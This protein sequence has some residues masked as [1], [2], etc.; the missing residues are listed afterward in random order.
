MTQRHTRYSLSL[1]LAVFLTG[2]A[3]TAGAQDISDVEREKAVSSETEDEATSR[4][5][6]QSERL[7]KERKKKQKTQG[8]VSKESV[9]A[10]GMSP[11]EIRR[12]KRRLERKNRQMID[13]L[14]RLIENDPYN[15]QKPQWMFQKAEL[16]WELR[17]MEYM[18]K[19]A[20]YNQ[21]LQAARQGTTDE[22]T[23]QEPAPD[24]EA[25]Q[26]IYKKIL[27][28][29]PD[30]QRLDEVIYRLG[31]GLL[32]ADKGTQ[33]ISY[34]QRLV[35]NYP[36]SKYIPDANLALAEY[37]FKQELL[38]AARDKYKAVLK[39]P[40]DPNY[41]YALY[42]LAWVFYNQNQYRQSIKTFK[43]VVER[44]NKKLGFQNQAINDMVLAYSEIQDGWEELRGYLIDQ[45]DK[46]LAYEKLGQLA[47]LYESQ[48][49]DREAIEVYN[50]FI[51]DRS[52]HSKVP[53]WMENIVAAKKRINVDLPK[54]ESTINEFVAYLSP[55]G[56]WWES[57][58][59]NPRNNAVLFTKASLAYLAN[60]YH[61]R[62]QKQDQKTFYASATKYYRKYIDRFPKD[63]ASF[64]MNYFLADILLTQLE[65]YQDAAERY[66]RVVEMYKKEEYPKA[67]EEKK[68]ELNSI[69]QD[70]AYGRVKAYDELVKKNHE[71]S[72][73]VK[74]ARFQEK[75][76]GKTYQA[77]NQEKGPPS[78]KEP[79]E[80]EP[81]LEYEKG[82]VKASDQYSE[83]F[84]KTDITPT[85]D[86]V[87]AEVYKARG[88]YKECID[89]YESIIENAPEH[90]YA[91][92][93]GNSLLEANYVLENWDEVERW[94]RHLLDNKIFD[95]TPKPK[96][97]SA[98]AFAINERAKDLKENDETR[99]AASELLRLA[100][101]FPDSKLTPG[102]IFNAAAIYES[103]D[104]IKKAV[105]QY[106]RVVAK[107]PKDEKAPEALFVLGLIAESR[108]NFAKAAGYFERL[109]NE[110]YK[111]SKKSAKA[112]YNAATLREAME[113]WTKAISTYEQY[114]ELFPDRDD[115]RK[116]KLKLAYLEKK[117]EN[118]EKSRERFGTFLER[119]DLKPPEE[120][121]VRTQI[122]LLLKKTQ[123]DEWKED[124]KEH[125][126]K[127]VKLWG[128]LPKKKKKKTREWAAHSRFLLAERQYATFEE[129]GLEFPLSQLKDSMKDKAE[130][131]SKAEKTYFKVI[132][133]KS[134]RWSSASAYR[135]GNMYSDYYQ[136]IRDLPLPEGLNQRQKFK[137]RQ[138]LDRRAAPLQ[139]KAVKAYETAL[140]VALR[141]QAYNEWSRKSAREISDLKKQSFPI[142][143]QKGVE[144]EHGQIKFYTPE[145]LVSFD[146]ALKRME[147]RDAR[148]PDEPESPEEGEEG[149]E[150]DDGGGEAEQKSAKAKSPGES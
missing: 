81:L 130:K 105:E 43:R 8:P 119:D 67:L 80:R 25:A 139:E 126:E 91:S 128:E 123:P 45:R 96:L 125:F 84:P 86:F 40:K 145:P 85:V 149:K 102:A 69:V 132:D 72:I 120:V 129:V 110:Q 74:M 5:Q 16:T 146:K 114:I 148:Q 95:V 82:F 11:E 56:T 117:R 23:C 1:G 68:K 88:N 55:G 7:D 66:A 124:S 143:G 41:D 108:A 31:S 17:N 104:E 39:H 18:R 137:Y 100:E 71:D 6:K 94:A 38:G 51:D 37:F 15:E 101:E 59:E 42:K 122:G 77:K 116:V 131:L 29:Y 47:G 76:G 144:P 9:E 61:K 121:E 52:N 65:K 34:L 111:D 27:T 150:G 10:Q 107:Y 75:H 36:N 58:D 53:T 89:R 28:Q 136:S 134:P 98:I 60:K 93:A 24:Y 57:N 79:N 142:T 50:Y 13:K 147:A 62:G 73:L 83:M 103:G 20:E 106:E 97:K 48:G 140:Q 138:T 63:P 141:L 26:D 21:C 64:D 2:L 87:A 12:T 46:K 90:R 3:S 70:A 14:N 54:L 4:V 115:I 32:E 113:Q 33:G 109:G 78:E 19:R 133:M 92:F 30:Y 22:S 118:H 35:K 44:S 127:V 135:I 112:V 99:K 49:K